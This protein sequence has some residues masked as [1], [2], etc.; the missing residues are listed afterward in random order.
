MCWAADGDP[1]IVVVAFSGDGVSREGSGA[2]WPNSCP[3]TQ[4]DLNEGP[5]AADAFEDRVNKRESAIV[6][7]AHPLDLWMRS[8]AQSFESSA[9]TL[10]L[11]R[12]QS[13]CA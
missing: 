6:D 2:S 10:S 9:Q 8:N 3:R 12:C 4:A 1:A 5:R 11:M 13:H 7:D